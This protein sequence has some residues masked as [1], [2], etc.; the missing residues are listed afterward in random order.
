[1]NSIYIEIYQKVYTS[2][3]FNCFLGKRRSGMGSS[4]RR[5]LLTIRSKKIS[6]PGSDADSAKVQAEP[7][8]KISHSPFWKCS[9]ETYPSSI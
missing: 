2:R 6:D 4:G 5:Q 3:D 8:D 9:Q 1:M 7:S